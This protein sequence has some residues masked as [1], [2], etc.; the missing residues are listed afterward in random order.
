MEIKYEVIRA[1]TLTA[2][3]KRSPLDIYS[4]SYWFILGSGKN[5]F[6]KRRQAVNN[7]RLPDSFGVMYSG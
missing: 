1:A 3:S 2:V 7:D 6:N 4:H 5:R